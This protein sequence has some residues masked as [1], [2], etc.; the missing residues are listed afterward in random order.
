MVLSLSFAFFHCLQSN[1]DGDKV[2]VQVV[3]P[4]KDILSDSAKTM[5][6]YVIGKSGDS[7][8][9]FEG[10]ALDG[11]W[12][13][14]LTPED[15]SLF[16]QLYNKE[17][18]LIS[19]SEYPYRFVSGSL[20]I[21]RKLEITPRQAFLD[22]TGDP[23]ILSIASFP[24]SWN[25]NIKWS[26]SNTN[27]ASVSSEGVV[28]QV[29]AGQC[30]I[31]AA[32]EGI[33]DSILVSVMGGEPPIT[34]IEFLSQPQDVQATVGEEASFSVSVNQS[35]VNYQWY[36]NNIA[37][38]NNDVPNLTINSVSLEDSG[39]VFYVEVYNE[40]EKLSS[41]TAVLHV[42]AENQTPD[43]IKTSPPVITSD[44][45][46]VYITLGETASFSITATGEITNIQWQ[47]DK[48]NIEGADSISLFLDNPT[49]DDNSSKY[50]AIVS[51]AAGSDTSLEAILNIAVIPV[52][53]SI[54]IQ[55][56]KTE[57]EIGEEAII[58]VKATGT[59]LTYQWQKDREDIEGENDSQLV[60]SKTTLE[61]EEKY[62][63]VVSNSEGS[64]VSQEVDLVVHSP[65][66]LITDIPEDTVILQDRIMALYVRAVGT[67][68]ILYRWYRNG[69]ALTM[70][71]EP[72]YTSQK[73]TM[74]NNG[75]KYYCKISNTRGTINSTETTVRIDAK[76]VIITQPRS[77][78]VD[79]GAQA[80]FSIAA[81]GG[82]LT[83]QWRRNGSV[84]QGE[85][86]SSY[87]ISVTS[88]TDD[89]SQFSCDVTNPAGTVSSETATL[90]VE[91]I[92]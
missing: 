78:T 14:D 26:S 9:V 60:I 2:K 45:Q 36:K 55:P 77:L 15:L 1:G 50:S 37:V 80:A 17:G 18:L 3:L 27:V 70:E 92:Q 86:F 76:P 59:D 87:T 66:I 12:I 52:A 79:E 58:F 8:V 75:D 23:K 61:D 64:V 54:E 46:D 24:S 67:N 21:E 73:L 30:Y 48:K 38:N 7:T 65:P 69:E 28:S 71:T 56:A 39:S 44:P 62:R 68:P 10:S 72:G 16:I 25:A 42:R 89:G 83:Y 35:D 74:A 53:P 29:A 85:V 33:S 84:L 40:F 4:N 32:S 47:K 82:S 51:N 11:E 20:I 6:L 49:M 57:V 88:I 43:T 19:T 13:V 31:K 90:T 63:V 22:L 41:S 91:P 5:R 34:E 81:T